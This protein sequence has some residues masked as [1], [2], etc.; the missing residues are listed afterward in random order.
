VV[1]HDAQVGGSL[2]MSGATFTGRNGVAVRADRLRVQGG[3]FCRNRFSTTGQLRLH[4]VEIGGPIDLTGGSLSNPGGQALSLDSAR[5]AGGVFCRAPFSAVGE[6]I[7]LGAHI[8][9]Q[10]DLTGGTF[11]NP[12]GDALSLDSARIAGSVVCGEGFSASGVVRMIGAEIG[13]QLAL[14]GGTFSNP[15]GDALVCDRARIVGSVLCGEGF[16]A[17][18]VVR[19]LGAEIGGQLNLTGCQLSNPGAV[20][21]VAEHADIDT[22]VFIK[23]NDGSSGGINLTGAH[24]RYLRDSPAAWQSYQRIALLDLTYDRISYRGWPTEHRLSWLRK[25]GTHENQP[26]EQLAATL[27]AQG[28]ERDARKILIAKHT[29]QRRQ[30]PWRIRMPALL[31]GALLAYGYRPLQRTLPLLVALYVLGAVLLYQARH[32]GAVIATRVP[33]HTAAAAASVPANGQPPQ[34]I[35]ATKHCPPDYSCFSPLAYTADVLIP[36]VNTHQT[37]YWTVISKH[38]DGVVIWYIR[39]APALGWIL[40]TAA[41]L[42]FT[43]LIRRD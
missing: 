17:S 14:T 39:L 29:Q 11:S 20:A 10:L 31:F 37:D 16:S 35:V 18:G 25:A 15:T 21:L 6:M 41:A 9:G 42:G 24:I 22:F 43:G 36:L 23:G 40:S 34:P 8:G 27:R 3:L 26:Y 5:V 13:G 33:V 30:Q 28:L 32:D 12:T 38:G 7:L 1:F 19:M 4:G 2:V